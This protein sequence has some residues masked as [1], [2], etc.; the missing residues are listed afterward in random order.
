MA[1]VAKQAGAH[2]DYLLD[3]LVNRW[4]EVADVADEWATWDSVAKEVF[5][6]EWGLKE[7]RLHELEGYAD[8]GKLTVEQAARYATLRELVAG[9]RPTLERLLAD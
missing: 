1:Q 4:R 7:E 5:Q 6:L 3:Y 9:Q 8:G 2:V